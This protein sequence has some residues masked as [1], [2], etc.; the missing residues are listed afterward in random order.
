MMELDGK[1]AERVLVGWL[2]GIGR[3]HGSSEAQ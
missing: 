1:D 3:G 2:L